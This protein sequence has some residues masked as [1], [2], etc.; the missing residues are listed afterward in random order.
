M[1]SRIFQVSE[2]PITENF[3]HEYDYEE[4]FVGR[5]A[6]YVSEVTYKSEDYI[7]DLKW[8]QN[9]AKGVKVNIKEGTITVTS[10][11]EYFDEKHD[12]FKELLQKLQ[13]ITLE[14]FIED[15]SFLDMYELKKNYDNEYGFYIDDNNEYCGLTT[16]DNWMRSAEEGKTYY[17]GS[18]MDYHF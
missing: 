18:I 8:L 6:D 11:K 16:I 2:N 17:V 9:V 1:H 15:K 12:N 5:I 14:E 3:K 4:G 13:D 10:K 7:N